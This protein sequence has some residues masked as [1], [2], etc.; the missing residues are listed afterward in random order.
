MN[1]NKINAYFSGVGFAVPKKIL[2]N[3]DLEK[4]VD[5]TDEWISSRT[6][7]KERHIAKDGEM[8]SDLGYEAGKKALANA[9]IKASELDMIIVCSITPDYIFPC[10][11]ALIQEKLD[12]TNAG[13]MDM[14]AACTGFIYGSSI[15]SQFIE[16][17]RYKHVLVIAAETMSRITDWSDRNTCVLFG[18]GS[19]AA[20]VSRAP[21]HSRSRIIDFVLR[22][23]GKYKDLLY[24]T[25][26]GSAKPASM[27]T[28]QNK[29]HYVRMEGSKVFKLAANSMSDSILELLKKNHMTHDDIDW[30]IPHQA[31]LRIMKQVAKNIDLPEEKVIINIEKYGNTSAATIPIALAEAVE[32]GTIKRGQKIVTVSFGGGMT[33]GSNLFIF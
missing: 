15:A 11:A 6:G 20:V 23:A 16:T 1:Q 27:E 28:I 14:E 4:M 30:L 5:T 3:A 26:G 24:I 32:N 19:G 21:A 13:T 9:G 25:A 10:T 17:G 29:E 8:T 33:W 22:G 31:N 7:I 2:T 18:D 12:A